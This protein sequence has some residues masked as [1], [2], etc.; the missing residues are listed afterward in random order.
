[1]KRRIL[2]GLL[3]L[4]LLPAAARAEPIDTVLAALAAEAAAPIER[5]RLFIL[6]GEVA[7]VYYID[8]VTPGRFRL[9]RNPRQ[10]GPELVIVDGMQWAR[11]RGGRWQRSPARDTDSLV[12]SMTDLFR[13]GL[14][15]MVEQAEPD[16]SR[17]VTG[18]MA[19]TNGVRCE[20]ELLMRIQADGLPS[21][22]RFEGVCGGKPF[23]FR[24]AF[25]FAGPLAI[26][27]PE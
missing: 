2:A 22:L 20:G 25:S 14:S 6:R 26:T 27:A 4:A 24:Q 8:R 12:P 7:E 13:T 21:L 10:G 18:G 23:R 16:G 3:I 9:T 11:T 19:W 1:M 17:S 5:A 15:R